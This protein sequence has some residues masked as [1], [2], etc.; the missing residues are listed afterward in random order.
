VMYSMSSTIFYEKTVLGRGAVMKYLPDRVD[1][2]DARGHRTRRVRLKLF[3]KRGI[4]WG[5]SAV[6]HGA[7][8]CSGQ[9]HILG[10]GAG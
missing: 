1:A 7:S 6:G 9:N 3:S 5:S 2:H 8:F 10:R 4:S